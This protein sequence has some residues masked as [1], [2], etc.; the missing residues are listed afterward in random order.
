MTDRLLQGIGVSPGVAFGPAVIVRLDVPDVPNR[1]IGDDEVDS[2]LTRLKLA[3]AGVAELLAALRDRV[4]ERAGRE[5]SHIFDAQIM[6]AEDPDFLR[7]VEQCIRDGMSAE[8]AYEFKALELRNTWSASGNALL[9]DRLAD[10]SAIHNRML[11]RLLGRTEEELW[12]LPEG[13]EVV[14]VAR[15]LSP[16]LTVQL[17]RD[18]VVGLL[19]EEGT[20]TSHAA[21]L[22]HSLGIPAVMGAVGALDRIRQGTVLLLDGQTGTILLDPN[23]AEIERARAQLSR[24]QKL[25]FE[26][27]AAVTQAAITPDGVQLTVMG[28]VDLPD[29]IAAAVR[30]DAQGVGLLRTEFLVTGRAHLPTEDEQADYFRRVCE[31][32]PEHP[33]VIRSFDLGGDKFP[34]A[35]RAPQEAN[36]FLGWRSIR[37]CLDHPE[38]FR[39]QLRAV[40]RAAADRKIQLMLPLVTQVD[41]VIQAREMLLEE[42]LK[43]ARNGVRAAASVPVGVMIET[44]AAAI[45]ADQ[46][47]QHSAFFSV[48]TNDLVQYTLAVDRGNA[49]LADRFTP[50][51]PAVVRQ[52]KGIVTAGQQAGI[53]VSVCGEMAADPL[54]VVLLIGLGYRCLSV[55]PPAI[56][57][58]KWVVRTVPVAVAEA[59]A[60]A[61]LAADRPADVTAALRDAVKDRF[62]PRVFE[63]LAALPRPSGPATLRS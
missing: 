30:L 33:V 9:R 40:L 42:A 19:S 48:G 21:I 52:L 27:E 38:I 47:A 55:G 7:Q 31:A 50:H 57:L 63:S 15:E 16:G 3:V 22:A 18:R 28:N 25:E 2:E 49:R 10:L 35:F 45:L 44:P 58:V 32:F 14:I 62:D 53:G 6:M 59:A 23:R 43:L 17:D 54:S 34:A 41:E 5:E 61:A 24:R 20:R 12:S 13:S 11:H 36:P 39:P 37:V 60:A 4:R 29:E 56:P 8:T 51:H 26:L 46:F 1:F